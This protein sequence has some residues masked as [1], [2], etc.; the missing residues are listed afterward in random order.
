MPSVRPITFYENDGVGKLSSLRNT[1]ATLAEMPQGSWSLAGIAGRFHR[2]DPAREGARQ[3]RRCEHRRSRNPRRDADR[4]YCYPVHGPPRSGAD[5]RRRSTSFQRTAPMTRLD[6]AP[7]VRGDLWNLS[8]SASSC[9]HQIEQIGTNLVSST[10][11]HGHKMTISSALGSKSHEKLDYKD[12][13]TISS[14]LQNCFSQILT[15]R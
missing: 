12:V 8:H 4:V 10:T 13:V 7:L 5:P 15:G 6:M 9:G 3:E 14:N 2:V 1:L 11:H